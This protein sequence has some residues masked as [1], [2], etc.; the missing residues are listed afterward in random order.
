MRNIVSYIPSDKLL[1]ETDAPYLA[2][3]P[4]R[5]KENEPAFIVDTGLKIAELRGCLVEEVAEIT[6]E[7]AIHV[8]GLEKKESL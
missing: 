7:N 2:P 5:G 6:T 1:I 4:N 3:V 8:F